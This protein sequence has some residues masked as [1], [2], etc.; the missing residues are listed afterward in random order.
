MA[1][2][3]EDGLLT[4]ADQLEQA[5]AADHQGHER[6]WAQGVADALA[7]LENLLRQRAAEARSSQKAF[8]EIDLTRPTL[9]RRV[10]EMRQELADLAG[11]AGALRAEVKGA[12]EA[13]QP[14]EKAA[15]LVDPLPIPAW[16]SA[17]PDFGALRQR[18]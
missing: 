2:T 18:A 5:L 16:A 15:P 8:G 13:F 9:V 10:A 14:Q 11:Q 12:A 4:A 17:V 3:Q 1:H 7:V 6:P